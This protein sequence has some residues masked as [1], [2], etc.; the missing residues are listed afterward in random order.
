MT[1]FF[2]WEGSPTKLEYRKVGTLILTSL[3]EGKG[4][5]SSP[6]YGGIKHH[7]FGPVQVSFRGRGDRIKGK[8]RDRCET[9]QKSQTQNQ[10]PQNKSRRILYKYSLSLFLCVCQPHP[11]M[12]QQAKYVQLLQLCCWNHPHPEVRSDLTRA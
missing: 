10:H 11:A 2:G 3:L 5:S 8:Y 12:P 4:F 7:L 6:L 1:N 9:C